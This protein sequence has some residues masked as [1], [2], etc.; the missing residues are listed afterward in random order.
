[1]AVF[2]RKGASK[3]N[4]KLLSFLINYYFIR[5]AHRVAFYVLKAGNQVAVFGVELNF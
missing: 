4:L 1:M 2:S 3:I 5:V